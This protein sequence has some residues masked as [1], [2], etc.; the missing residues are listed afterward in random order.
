MKRFWIVAAALAA[1]SC[2]T[3][4][5]TYYPIDV[6]PELNYGPS[7]WLPP[8]EGTCAKRAR[9]E[10][11]RALRDTGYEV[12]LEG[13]APAGAVTIRLEETACTS[14][15][16][17]EGKFRLGL[18]LLLTGPDGSEL[19]QRSLTYAYARDKRD[20][21]GAFKDSISGSRLKWEKPQR[22][23]EYRAFEAARRELAGIFVPKREQVRSIRVSEC[24]VEF[25]EHGAEKAVVNVALGALAACVMEMEAGPARARVHRNVGMILLLRG[26]R[27]AAL[28]AFDRATSEDPE[29]FQDV[30]RMRSLLRE[31]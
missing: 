16:F 14:E 6:S 29:L 8:V 21:S 30:D 15:L 24:P 9:G 25:P 10:L 31:Q 13:E 19:A 2:E 7:Y 5:T 18:L 3:P 28:N 20:T 26:N 1:A 22:S 17:G 11:A 4:N 23:G 12:A 27:T